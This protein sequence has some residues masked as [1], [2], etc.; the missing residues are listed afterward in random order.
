MKCIDCSAAGIDAPA[1]RIVDG[2]G[3]CSSHARK[4]FPPGATL[5]P[6]LSESVT[7]EGTSMRTKIDVD[8]IVADYKAGT[9][10]MDLAEKYGCHHTYVRGVLK[11]HGIYGTMP[12]QRRGRVPRDIAPRKD[13]AV[14]AVPAGSVE[15][16]EQQRG[17]ARCRVAMFEVEGDATSVQHAVDAI[18]AALESRLS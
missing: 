15:I 1:T 6:E 17:Q 2:K 8:G 7:R 14:T 18:K 10:V 5:P 4:Y 9:P 12:A 16:S 11:K 3:Y 13:A